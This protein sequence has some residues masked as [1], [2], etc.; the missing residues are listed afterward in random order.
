[1][2]K[3]KKTA[4]PKGGIQRTFIT[5]SVS[6]KKETQETEEEEVIDVIEQAKRN[7]KLAK[8]EAKQNQDNYKLD[9]DAIRDNLIDYRAHEKALNIAQTKL[10]SDLFFR[11]HVPIIKLSSIPLGILND[12]SKKV[13]NVQ[14]PRTIDEIYNALLISRRMK[15]DDKDFFNSLEKGKTL[16]IISWLMYSNAFEKYIRKVESAGKEL[17]KRDQIK[18]PKEAPVTAVFA[19]ASETAIERKEIVSNK[20]QNADID[21]GDVNLFE[22]DP[23]EE[24]VEYKTTKIYDFSLPK[25]WTGLTPF[26]LLKQSTKCTVNNEKSKGGFVSTIKLL[27]E[28]KTF[29]SEVCTTKLYAMDYAA[30]LAIKFINRPNLVQRFP[31]CWKDFWY[32]LDNKDKL[33]EIERE[34]ELYKRIDRIELSDKEKPKNFIKELNISEELERKKNQDLESILK[35][36][37]N[38]EKFN[39]ARESRKSLPV[40]QNLDSVI[41]TVFS[42][43]VVVISSSTGSGKSTQIPLEILRTTVLDNLKLANILVAQPKRISTVSLANYVS[44]MALDDKVG[45]VVGYAIRL[46]KAISKNTRIQFVTNGVLIRAL[47]QNPG[48]TG[49]THIVIDEVHERTAEIDA[50]LYHLKQLCLKRTDL[51]VILMSATSHAESLTDYFK[52]N[53]TILNIETERLYSIDTFYLNDIHN[54]IDN[55]LRNGSLFEYNSNNDTDENSDDITEEIG[56]SMDLK[57]EKDQDQL[58]EDDEDKEEDSNDLKEEANDESVDADSYAL[59]EDNRKMRLS[60]ELNIPRYMEFL[61]NKSKVKILEIIS[62]ICIKAKVVKGSILVFLPGMMEINVIHDCLSGFKFIKEIY[63]LHSNAE[64]DPRVFKASDKVKVILSTDVSETGLTIPDVSVVIDSG[65]VNEIRYIPSRNISILK[66]VHASRASLLQRRGRTGRVSNGECYHLLSETTFNRLSSY[67]IPEI[68]RIPLDELY[69]NLSRM[70]DGDVDNVLLGMISAP[71]S[72]NISNASKSLRQLGC[73]NDDNF[74]TP[75]GRKISD[76]PIQPKIAK[77]LIAGAKLRCLDKVLTYASILSTNQNVISSFVLFRKS[78]PSITN[79]YDAYHSARSTV[80]NFANTSIGVGQV[81]RKLLSLGISFDAVVEIERYRL[82]IAESLRKYGLLP[83]VNHS[84]LSTYI[85]KNRFSKIPP[86]F[87]SNISTYSIDSYTLALCSFPNVLYRY[88][89]GLRILCSELEV[90]YTSKLGLTDSTEVGSFY[91]SP[92]LITQKN[93]QKTITT[94]ISNIPVGIML[95]CISALGIFYDSG[96]FYDKHGY[97]CVSLKN[98]PNGK[99]T[100]YITLNT[101]LNLDITTSI[102]NFTNF[103]R[104]VDNYLYNNID[105]WD[106]KI[107]DLIVNSMNHLH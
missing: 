53:S 63:I 70:Y 75:L 91:A 89:K 30:V 31:P 49:I 23:D 60:E 83:G 67:K 38:S 69:I 29:I 27:A 12:D 16:D 80:L 105:A 44:Q 107:L 5:S 57:E 72:T 87:N 66:S 22:I 28:N 78:F 96:I 1:M 61:I 40:M 99:S 39:K 3:K 42:N 37:F 86:Q 18:K 65:F 14:K 97:S 50:I 56:I 98:A 33:E 82:D 43:Q 68:R 10:D 106:D 76:L 100:N 55:E 58:H 102:Y 21:L 41:K 32:E 94:S 36:R 92:S 25:G 4:V 101:S 54:S 77:A 34:T 8:Q 73:L 47:A 11:P 24:E 48:L 85:F 95:L 62:L 7:K 17:A 81:K 93:S 71:D 45:G 2:A 64:V 103:K 52:G 74:L 20:A 13:L 6:K 46:S 35:E 26:T 51:R 90:G 88:T 84:D 19:K 9:L 104:I 79:E 59:T 15:I